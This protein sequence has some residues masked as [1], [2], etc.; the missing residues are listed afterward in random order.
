VGKEKNGDVREEKGDPQGFP[1]LNEL[2][3]VRK[4]KKG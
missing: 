4:K 2:D 3:H 1:R